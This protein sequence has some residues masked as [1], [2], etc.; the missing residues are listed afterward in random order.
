MA[1]FKINNGLVNLTTFFF[2]YSLYVDN[3]IIAIIYACIK[4]NSI[5]Q[6]FEI[7]A[8]FFYLLKYRQ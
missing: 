6:E 1:I 5:S 4:C 2:H 7:K 3:F 8:K